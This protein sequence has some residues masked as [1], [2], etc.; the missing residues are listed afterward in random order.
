MNSRRDRLGVE[1][2]AN[3]G[4][5]RESEQWECSKSSEVGKEKAE[6]IKRKIS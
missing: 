5:Q 1:A 3:V 4:K 2:G 6:V